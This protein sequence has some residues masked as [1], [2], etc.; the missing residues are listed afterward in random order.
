MQGEREVCERQVLERI[1]VPSKTAIFDRQAFQ[2]FSLSTI[3]TGIGRSTDINALMADESLDAFFTTSLF[4][5]PSLLF[6]CLHCAAKLEIRGPA[7]A[8]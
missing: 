1:R 2:T 5:T 6:L 7:A 3:T 8:Y 4:A